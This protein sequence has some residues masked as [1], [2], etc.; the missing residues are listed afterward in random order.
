M[1]R[2]A[3]D[4]RGA[5][6]CPSRKAGRPVA[7]GT[8]VAAHAAEQQ[9]RADIVSAPA[10]MATVLAEG[11]RALAARITWVAQG[12]RAALQRLLCGQQPT[13]E[14]ARTVSLWRPDGSYA[15]L[16]DTCLQGI[17]NDLAGHSVEQLRMVER[18]FLAG[19]RTDGYPNDHSRAAAVVA[20]VRATR[21]DHEQLTAAVTPAP[22]E[23]PATREQTR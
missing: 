9:P 12:I 18:A 11:T 22:T 14:H 4:P 23:R 5:K 2:S 20:Q 19:R 15:E 3:T 10:A 17:A 13:L 6:R 1:C 21:G 8:A 7:A 16:D